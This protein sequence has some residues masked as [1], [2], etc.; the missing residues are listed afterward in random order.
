MSDDYDW[1]PHL[2]EGEEVLWQGRP[3]QR[4]FFWTPQEAGTLVV[5]IGFFIF[6][7]SSFPGEPSL[8]NPADLGVMG[9]VFLAFAAIVIGVRVFHDLS[10]RRSQRYAI[11]NMRALL[12]A[13]GRAH[14][15]RQVHLNGALNIYAEHRFYPVVVFSR[16]TRE[17]QHFRRW[18]LL[19]G[20]PPPSH[21]NRGG[22][23]F[24]RAP[25]DGIVAADI[26]RVVNGGQSL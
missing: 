17:I 4:F 6:A 25:E 10:R 2:Q 14:A 16:S 11:T 22:D 21:D 5:T 7:V 12:A 24:F 3:D 23:L 8:G 19:F 13:V 26:A 20:P 9:L 18:L 15:F 1:T